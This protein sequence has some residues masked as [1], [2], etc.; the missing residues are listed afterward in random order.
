MTVGEHFQKWQ[1]VI[2]SA[3]II[4]NVFL[5]GFLVARVGGPNAPHAQR[6]PM[7]ME[8]R[9]LP[10]G[11]SFEAREEIE[12]EM[13]LHRED[14]EQAYERLR[15]VQEEINDI[16]SED[17]FDRGELEEAFSEM[18]EL[19]SA[20]KVR[21]REA[22]V[23]AMRDVSRENRR[24]LVRVRREVDRV[25]LKRPNRVD[26]S[27]W[28]FSMEDG[29]FTFDLEGLEELGGLDGIKAL[30]NLEI[31]ISRIDEDDEDYNEDE[32]IFIEE[33]TDKGEEE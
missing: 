30:E 26:G 21:M 32:L 16:T 4:L 7:Q 15:E 13:R 5:I 9:T 22:Y 29:S 8:L 1:G 25:R 23:N 28:E 24:E 3:S 20:I 6:V 10:P 19:E 31:I 2:L 27:R 17:D 14:V 12:H 11:I 18:A 33:D